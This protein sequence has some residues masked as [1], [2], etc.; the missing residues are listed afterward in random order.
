VSGEILGNH[1]IETNFLEKKEE[2]KR[3]A[4][5]QIT[6]LISLKAKKGK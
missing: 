3:T 2:K 4:D 1:F 6:V 5:G